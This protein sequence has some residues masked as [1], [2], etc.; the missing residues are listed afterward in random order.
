M[1][2]IDADVLLDCIPYCDPNCDRNISKVGAIADMV[3]LVSEAPTIDAVEVVRCKDCKYFLPYE[4][5]KGEKF[6]FCNHPY[7]GLYGVGLDS[8]CYL[9]ERKEE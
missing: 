9:G 2:L 1:R 7:D 6:C 4:T 3:M 5:A 8:F